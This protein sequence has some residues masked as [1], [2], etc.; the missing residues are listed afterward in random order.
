MDRKMETR[1]PEMMERIVRRLVP[2]V[3]REHVIGD[4]SERYVSPGQY[5]LDAVRT[6]PFVIVSRIRRTQHPVL[7]AFLAFLLWFAVF[8]GNMQ[9]S[10]LVATVPTLAGVVALV[11]RDVYR[12]PGPMRPR[13]A[14]MDIAV[15][16]ALIAFS[17]GLIALFA[18]HLLLSKAALFVG[19]PLSCVLLYFLRLQRP[20]GEAL[21]PAAARRMSLQELRQ[22]VRA[23]E[24]TSQ[25]A[26]RIEIGACV[27]VTLFFGAMIWGAPDPIVK[28]GAACVVGAA[29]FVGGFLRRVSRQRRPMPPDLD[30]SQSVTFYR[31]A[32]ERAKGLL[33][34]YAWWYVLPLSIGPAV[35]MVG[36]AIRRSEPLR[37]LVMLCFVALFSGLLV[38]MQSV[39]VKGLQK[40]LDQLATVEEKP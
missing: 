18:P 10:W 24:A 12:T 20:G 29:L 38:L 6:V 15:Y 37:A 5:L 39:M 28:A 33:R 30:F 40:R 25:R 35:I 3:S 13:E 7:V 22:E 21:S 9:K 1:P 17:Q 31:E 26:L 32:L 34:T 16:A 4:L 36:G 27:A 11:L 8:Y 14:A 2:V 19:F 23:Y